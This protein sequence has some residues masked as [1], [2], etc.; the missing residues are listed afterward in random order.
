MVLPKEVRR[1]ARRGQTDVVAAWLESG[2]DVDDVDVGNGKERTLLLWAAWGSGSHSGELD[3]THVALARTLVERGA[4]VNHHD[5]VGL[6]ALHI[7]AVGR[8][9]SSP[10]MVVLLLKAGPRERSGR[11]E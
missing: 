11:D 9:D 7:A 4:D 3:E 6:T 8:S 10:A 2:G 5:L 1:A